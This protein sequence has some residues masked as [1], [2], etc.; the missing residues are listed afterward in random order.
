MKEWQLG[1][2]ETCS[3][4]EA[5]PGERGSRSSWLSALVQVRSPVKVSNYLSSQNTD[6]MVPKGGQ[7]ERGQTDSS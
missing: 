3:V 7:E 5:E 6:D 1:E 2:A 4:P